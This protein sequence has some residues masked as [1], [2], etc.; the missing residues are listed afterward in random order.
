VLT[1]FLN[2]EAAM[3]KFARRMMVPIGAALTLWCATPALASIKAG[4]YVNEIPVGESAGVQLKG[5][6]T[7]TE[8]KEPLIGST[9]VKC[10]DTAEGTVKPRG[11]GAIT[12]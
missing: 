1:R 6:L 3:A 12:K 9:T 5:N 4:W 10:E 7:L 11:L 2:K 8:S